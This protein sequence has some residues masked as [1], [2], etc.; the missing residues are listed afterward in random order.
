MGGFWKRG[1][2]GRL[3]RVGRD[4]VPLPPDDTAFTGTQARLYL[5]PSAAVVDVYSD[6]STVDERL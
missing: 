3:D 5:L 6:I 2:T 4:I 1:R